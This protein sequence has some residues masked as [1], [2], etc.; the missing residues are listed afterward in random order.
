MGL[1]AES[2]SAEGS[3][4][5][6]TSA[7][8]FAVLDDGN[9]DDTQGLVAPYYSN[10]YRYYSNYYFL[11]IRSNVVTFRLLFAKSNEKVITTYVRVPFELLY[12]RPCAHDQKLHTCPTFRRIF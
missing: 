6:S 10:Y 11:A 3:S 1:M 5:D 4:Q 8:R 2:D 7:N 9:D 12:A